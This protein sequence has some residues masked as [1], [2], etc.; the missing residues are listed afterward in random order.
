MK[1]LL[2]KDEIASFYKAFDKNPWCYQCGGCRFRQ[3]HRCTI[4][5]KTDEDECRFR[6]ER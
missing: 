1:R 3:R 4:L 6:R 5:K 2:T